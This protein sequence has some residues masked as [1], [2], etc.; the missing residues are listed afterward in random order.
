MLSTT[1]NDLKCI[2]FG[3]DTWVYAY[4]L[5]KASQSSEYR[6]AGKQKQK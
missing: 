4:D 3:D 6:V 5:E 1:N 2:I